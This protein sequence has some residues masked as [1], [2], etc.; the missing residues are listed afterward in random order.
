[1]EVILKEDLRGLGYKNDTV[2]VKPGYGRNY[3]I[4]QGLAMVANEVN[5]KIAS[6]NVS[7]AAHKAARLKEEAEALATQLE[8]VTLEITAQAADTGKIFGAVT[9]FQLASALKDQRIIIDRKDISF[10]K[11]VKALGVHEATLTL[12]KEVVHTLKFK[13][14]ATQ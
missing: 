10:A 9:P 14:V 3:L 2:K 4:P 13:V 6:E 1:M 12:H 5:K 11:P 8:Q 7:Q